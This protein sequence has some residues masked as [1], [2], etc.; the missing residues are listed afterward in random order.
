[1][2]IF[3]QFLDNTSLFYLIFIELDAVYK[4]ADIKKKILTKKRKSRYLQK[5]RKLV[6]LYYTRLDIV[7]SVYKLRQFLSYFYLVHKFA[8]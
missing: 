7:F 6:H 1:M 3:K 2:V 5:I 4:L 8:F